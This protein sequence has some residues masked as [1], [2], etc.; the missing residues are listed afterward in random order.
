[1]CFLSL[2]AAHSL[3]ESLTETSVCV[4]FF[5]RSDTLVSRPSRFIVSCLKAFAC[6]V[7]AR[8]EGSWCV[9]RSDAALQKTL[10]YACGHSADCGAV[11]PSEPCYSPVSVRAHCSYAANSYYQPRER[12]RALLLRRQQLLPAE[13]RRHLRLRRHGQPHRHRSQYV[14]NRTWGFF[15]S[16]LPHMNT[17][18]FYDLRWPDRF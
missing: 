2:T 4:L 10:D 16:L 7:F 1:V 18:S 12:A 13:Q 14:S 11:L 15:V 6:R 8:A 17:R 3:Q 9:C 5:S